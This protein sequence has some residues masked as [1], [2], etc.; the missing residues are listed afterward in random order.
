[1][2][3][4]RDSQV[5]MNF[6][7]LA[8][9]VT[10][11]VG[12]L[13][14]VLVLVIGITDDAVSQPPVVPVTP[15]PEPAAA[16]PFRGDRTLPTLE[17]RV[18]I[19]RSRLQTSDQDVTRLRSRLGELHEQAKELLDQVQSVQP[20]D[21]KKTEKPL[22]PSN[23]KDV[24]FRPPFERPTKKAPDL[25]LVLENNRVAIM[26]LGELDKKLKVRSFD[27]GTRVVKADAGDFD[28]E[29][30]VIDLLVQKLRQIKSV[31]KSGRPGETLAQLDSPD[32][33]VMSRLKSLNP[34]SSYLQ[35][36]VYPDSFEEF[37]SF[38]EQAWKLKFDVNWIPL[39]VVESI[40]VGG[41]GGGGQVQ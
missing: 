16:E 35:F 29:E 5:E 6:D 9:S 2:A 20:A 36:V 23:V 14:L 33:Q 8:D 18:A 28:F 34:T 11:L 22:E 30:T 40:S 10:N 7:G 38:R 39:T 12:A 32:S 19:L 27:V 37:R 41:G 1:M 17:N 24:R 15:S 26:D 13:I 4:S 3:R 31:R 25:A 21:D